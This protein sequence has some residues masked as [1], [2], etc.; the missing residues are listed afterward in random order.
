MSEFI[1]PEPKLVS[2]EKAI[3]SSGHHLASLAALDVL[4]DGG[5]VVY[6]AIAGA[7]VLSVVLP[8]ACGL[9]GDMCNA[10]L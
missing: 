5:N 8:Y 6:A 3:V 9:G 4:K 1:I 2:G 10:G 7:A